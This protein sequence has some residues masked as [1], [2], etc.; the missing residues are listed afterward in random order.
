MHAV[1]NMAI[2]L[3]STHK[4][5]IARNF[6]MII[7]YTNINSSQ[8]KLVSKWWKYDTAKVA[9]SNSHIGGRVKSFFRRMTTVTSNR[10][11]FWFES[12]IRKN[13]A[14][15]HANERSFLQ[16]FGCIH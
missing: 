11:M 2:L 3:T 13:E 8:N 6:V 10:R 1:L 7:I 15:N 12:S 16:A 14:S 5:H 9:A 4:N